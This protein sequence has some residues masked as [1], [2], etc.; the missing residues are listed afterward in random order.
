M[1]SANYAELT[2]P[3]SRWL[4]RTPMAHEAGRTQRSID[5]GIPQLSGID[6]WF[7]EFNESHQFTIGS[8]DAY[9]L[10]SGNTLAVDSIPTGGASGGVPYALLAK[11]DADSGVTDTNYAATVATFAALLTKL[12][13]DAGVT[14]VNY[15]STVTSLPGLL[16]KL[17]A[18]AGVGNT[19]YSAT[20]GGLT[21]NNVGGNFYWSRH[22]IGAPTTI[23]FY[24]DRHVSLDN[25]LHSSV[26][27]GCSENNAGLIAYQPFVNMG[28][29]TGNKRK[30]FGF[31]SRIRRMTGIVPTGAGF[32]GIGQY[33]ST[34]GTPLTTAGAISQTT[35]DRYIGFY[36]DASNNVFF[37]M[38]NG[39]AGGVSIFAGTLG[40]S[41]E[42]SYVEFRG[43]LGNDA[44]G[45]WT[46]GYIDA[47]FNGALVRSSSAKKNTVEFG[48][49]TW[50]PGNEP[51]VPAMAMVRTAG[52]GTTLYQVDAM[53]F[54]HTRQ[55]TH[56]NLGG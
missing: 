21:S 8:V 4:S 22:N 36:V 24:S 23:A 28:L 6:Y 17:D 30:E 12:D 15:A 7:C 31:I 37:V 18:D 3:G 46:D 11:L 19:N 51:I 9:T 40:I 49:M 27:I 38:N 10:A 1:S 29:S 41:G 47:Y 56:S 45:N 25:E 32:F 52:T 43:R 16:A 39:S 54:W 55:I 53:G 13:A 14:D 42:F 34:P 2:A 26:K 20:L 48:D 50:T 44:S 35:N 33:V 5:R